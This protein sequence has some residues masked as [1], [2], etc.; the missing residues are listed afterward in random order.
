V[1]IARLE[2]LPFLA[3]LVLAALLYFVRLGDRALW[4]EEVR[5]AEIAREMRLNDDYL[6]PTINGHT[7]YDKPLGS[8]WLVVA[9]SWLRGGVDETAARL[10]CAVSGLLG[11]LLIMLVA[12][13]LFDD[14]SAILAGIILATSFSFVFF[15]RTASTDVETLT[16][17]LAAL[18]LFLRNEERPD[19]WWVVLLWLI[20]ALTSLT[21]GLLGFVLPVLVIGLYCSLGPGGSLVSRNRW[22]FN[23]KSLLA[24]PL[25][26]LVYLLPF[27][28]S[29]GITQSAEGLDMVFRENIRRFYNPV[30]HRGPIWLYAG[31]IFVLM[32]P[33]SPL[34]PAALV[35]SH[36]RCR[37]DDRESRG[38]RFA[39]VYFWG[40]F[41]FFTLSSSRRSYYLLPILPAA[42]LLLA[43]LLA[44]RDF[45]S[46]LL[47]GG[48]LLIAAVS[49]LSIAAPF[50]ASGMGL[51]ELP[52][53]WLFLILWMLCAA[54]VVLTLRRFNVGRIAGSASVIAASFMAYL[55]L[56]ALP[57][58]E[59]FRTRRRF[60]DEVNQHVGDHPETLALFHNREIVFYLSRRD[61]VPEYQSAEALAHDLRAGKVRWLIARRQD[62]RELTPGEKI[63]A[64]EESFPWESREQ[65]R[66]KL[67]L[68][69]VSSREIRP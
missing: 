2:S 3:V 16:G 33:W 18:W 29:Y 1:K 41:L 34:L 38:E 64:G 31:V 68:L 52:C 19:G 66:H 53:R 26:V 21:K 50:A 10:P 59:D 17:V 61:P 25:A 40:L 28:L 69:N 9:A 42:S 58:L 67:V 63:V 48:Y 60:A 15:S 20:M 7:Y 54:G 12:R 36:R 37:G 57:G 22:L 35:R 39:L 30:N 8:Y 51:P 44:D 24:V 45:A 46:R 11:V 43:R 55:F 32:A 62:L 14:R 27:L 13:R 47:K 4:S 6:W 5:W 49:V 23:R 65:R 56:F